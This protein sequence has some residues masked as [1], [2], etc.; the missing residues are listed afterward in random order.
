MSKPLKSLAAVAFMLAIAACT[1]TSEEF[2]VVDP[3]PRASD[4]GF[5]G[6]YN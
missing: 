5:V 3:A 6:K 1:N 2:V 4:G